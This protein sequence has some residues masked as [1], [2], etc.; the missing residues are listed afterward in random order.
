MGRSLNAVFLEAETMFHD[1]R[2]ADALTRYFSVI[3]GAPRFA[4][5]RYRVADALLNL[6]ERTLAK[7]VYK[8]LAW[9]YMKSGQPLL[10]LVAAK[11]V[12]ALD[13]GAQDLL[14]ILAELYSSESDRVAEIDIPALS[15][16]AGD[17]G[18]DEAEPVSLSPA[19]GARLAADLDAVTDVPA[20]IPLVPLFSHLTEDA[21]I[22]LVGS[23]RL[24]RHTHGERIVSEGDPGDSFFMLAEGTVVV[25]K[26][27]QGL[28]TVLAHLGQGAVFGEMALVSSAP[29]TATVSAEGDV[30]LLELSRHDIE[31]HAGELESVRDALKK[32]TRARFLANLAATNP[33]FRPLSRPDRR[34][35][36]ARF[37]SKKLHAR[38]IAIGQGDAGRA[39]FL[40]LRGQFSVS[41]NDEGVS[42]TVATLRGGDVFGEISLLHDTPATATVTADVDSEVLCLAREDFAEVLVA[43]PE[44]RDNLNSL[45]EERLRTLK[46]QQPSAV[47]TRDSEVLF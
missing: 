7:D 17:E 43:H 30:D 46:A 37:K 45:S 33:V 34:A 31:G 25:S 4:K 15:P 36:M 14:Q 22:R 19:E 21:F 11:M 44:V 26:R 9:H 32:F 6:G 40:V 8:S 13:P 20:K 3:R 16:T 39:L 10:A 18:L 41:R 42:T 28:D 2:Y 1:G 24:R 5:A 27:L 23:L 47:A 12:L 35:L 38:D 29:R